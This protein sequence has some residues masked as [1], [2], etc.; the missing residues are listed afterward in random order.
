MSKIK[1]LIGG[2]AADI[3]KDPIENNNIYEMF[4]KTEGGLTNKQMQFALENNG[5]V[6][7][8]SVYQCTEHGE[9][10][11][12]HFYKFTETG[13]EDTTINDDDKI[14]KLDGTYAGKIPVID[15]NGNLYASNKKLSDL[16]VQQDTSATSVATLITALD[17]LRTAG[18]KILSIEFT[19]SSRITYTQAKI[20]TPLTTPSFTRTTGGYVLI[21]ADKKTIM[22]FIGFCEDTIKYTFG[23]PIGY[24][25]GFISFITGQSNA[26][27][28]YDFVISTST[29]LD[30]YTVGTDAINFDSSVT[31]YTINYI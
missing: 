1:T 2:N 24:R 21:E 20:T 23:L 5:F 3:F 17:T 12:N 26:Y 10:I 13:W 30:I 14:S 18:K 7:L 22:G 25:N 31:S 6:K 28:K 16:G 15:Q 29:N 19:P 27:L 8:G 9:Y 4:D 11:Q